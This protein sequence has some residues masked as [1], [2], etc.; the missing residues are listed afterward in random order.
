MSFDG[1]KS[2]APVAKL[3]MIFLRRAFRGRY[4]VIEEECGIL[5]RNAL[6]QVALLLDGPRQQWSEHAP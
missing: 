2:V 5:G 4:L 1:S 6:N 3:D